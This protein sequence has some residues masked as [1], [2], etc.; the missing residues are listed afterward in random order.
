MKSP[1]VKKILIITK[2]LSSVSSGSSS[3]LSSSKFG[4]ISFLASQV[5]L[6][7]GKTSIECVAISHF[8][9]NSDNMGKSGCL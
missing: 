9:S 3:I 2:S 7:G 1:F 4:S 5:R 8:S 6:I